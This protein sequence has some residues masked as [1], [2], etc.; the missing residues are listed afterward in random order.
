MSHGESLTGV[1]RPRTYQAIDRLVEVGVLDE[2]TGG[3]RNRIWV[4][5]EVMT[6]L[7]SL[8]E[9]IGVRSKPLSRWQ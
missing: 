1:S 8:E 5:S 6:E 3:G 4:A 7:R 9:L 2:I